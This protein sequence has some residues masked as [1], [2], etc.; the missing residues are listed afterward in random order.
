[1]TI[2]DL[3]ILQR[4]YTLNIGRLEGQI[5]TLNSQKTEAENQRLNLRKNKETYSKSVEIMQIVQK[6]AQDKILRGLEIIINHVLRSILGS[7][8]QFIVEDSRRGNYSE[9]DFKI[10]SP[11]CQVP[12]DPIVTESGG[13]LDLVSIALRIALME[14]NN[15]KIDG[16]L[17]LDESFKHLSTNHVKAVA[18][19]LKS[20]SQKLDRQIILISHNY[21]FVEEA[22]N[23]IEVK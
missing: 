20:L 13:I 8:Y 7:D 18:Q 22:D 9:L 5:S 10:K 1:M 3:E 4:E 16:F 2:Q 17:L 11:N 19:L 15:P 6:Q 21:R 14:L 12:S 23:I